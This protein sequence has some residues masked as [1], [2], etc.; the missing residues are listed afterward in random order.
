MNDSSSLNRMS[1]AGIVA[2]DDENPARPQVELQAVVPHSVR[3][4]GPRPPLPPLDKPRTPLNTGYT[5]GMGPGGGPGR[6][7]PPYSGGGGSRPGTPG[8]HGKKLKLQRPA[9]GQQL[10]AMIKKNM[11][12]KWRHK[13]QLV[14]VSV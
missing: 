8:L 4:S 2:F 6:G 11:I 7:P 3:F 1:S 9:F 14:M 12:V 5:N 10:K 13:F